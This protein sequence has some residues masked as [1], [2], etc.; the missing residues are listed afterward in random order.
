MDSCSSDAS[1]RRQRSPS[2]SLDRSAFP[3]DNEATRLPKVTVVMPAHNMERYVERA[4]R[5]AIDQT[6]PNLDVLVVNDGS[7]DRTAEIVERFA[8]SHSRVRMVTSANGG[9]AAARNLG[10][11]LADSAYVAFLD[12]DDL[13]APRKI[14]KQVAA[15]AAHGHGEDW[16]ACYTLY[17]MIDESDTII[18]NGPSSDERGAFFDKHLEWNHVGNG[19]SLLVR[20]DAALAVG[21]FNPD[22]AKHGVGGCEDFEFQLKLLRRYKME[23]VREYEVGYRIHETQMSGD[24]RRMRLGRIAVIEHVAAA[25][26]LPERRRKRLLAQSYLMVAQSFVSS[27]HWGDALRWIAAAVS[28]SPWETAI[29]VKRRLGRDMRRL[30]RRINRGPRQGPQSSFHELD[31]NDDLDTSSAVSARQFGSVIAQARA[32]SRSIAG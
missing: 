19:S 6:Y 27:R 5:S 30:W 14:E 24:M 28:L 15:L 9:V 3:W 20:R 31:P 21:G 29:R 22:Y 2:G 11:E 13:W 23:L 25:M 16:A 8:R 26:N 10:L 17:R 12:A 32:R 7:T 1:E 18:D 4:L